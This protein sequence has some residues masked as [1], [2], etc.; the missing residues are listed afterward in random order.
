MIFYVE[1]LKK[2]TKKAPRNNEF[3]KSWDIRQQ[4]KSVVFIHSNN[5][6]L[7]TNFFKINITYKSFKKHKILRYKCH[8]TCILCLCRTL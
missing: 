2:S 7:E 1:N 6:Q 5:K 4:A 3:R 8:D